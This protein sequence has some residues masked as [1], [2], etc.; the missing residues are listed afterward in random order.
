MS[1]QKGFRRGQLV[2]WSSARSLRKQI[3]EMRTV[4]GNGP[5][6]VAHVLETPV[7]RIVDG[8]ETPYQTLRLRHDRDLRRVRYQDKENFAAVFFEPCAKK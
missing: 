4:L 7:K 6:R 8:K 2:R 3:D 5:F 1:A